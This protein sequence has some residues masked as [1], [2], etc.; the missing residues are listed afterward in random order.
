MFGKSG[1]KVELTMTDLAGNFGAELT[2]ENTNNRCKVANLTEQV[3]MA[4][5]SK[6]VKLENYR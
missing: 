5:N 4:N 2:D 1:Q 3:E 6:A